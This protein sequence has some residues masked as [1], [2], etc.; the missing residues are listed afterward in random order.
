MNKK[1]NF[2]HQL[3]THKRV[4]FFYTP[5]LIALVIFNIG[6]AVALDEDNENPPVILY[7]LRDAIRIAFE[8]NLNIQIQEKEVTASRSDIITARS[9]FFPQV[10]ANASYTHNDK[11]LGENIFSGYKN[12]NQ[13]GLT[14]G[15]SIYSGGAN[16]AN[17]RQAQLKLRIQEETLNARKL[18][19]EFETKRLY[20]GLLLAYETV[21]IT[22]DLFDQAQAHYNDVQHKFDQGTSSRFDVL[23][24]KVQVSK[25]MPEL[26]KAKNAVDLI[27]AD[28][29]KLLV[30]K[31]R[32]ELGVEDRLAYNAIKINEPEF[33]K[34]AYLNQPQMNLKALGIDVNKWAI[35]LARSSYRPQINAELDYSYR[36]NNLNDMFN[37][38]QRN[39][40]AGLVVSVPIFDGFS[41]K[42]K[43]DA[44]KARYAEALL[45]KEDTAEQIAVDIKK[46]CL[47]LQQA[48]A[49]I[50]YTK[51][52]IGEAREA[53]K[54]SEV[55]YDNGEGTN[56][57]ILDA[58]VSLS[59]IE[60]DYSEGIYDY[61]MA[62]AFLNKTMG[63]IFLEETKNEKK[64]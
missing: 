16:M 38:S 37:R 17:F 12:D 64:D 28:L 49:I 2:W 27:K 15:Q 32:R 33:L 31:M 24:S 21:R 9:V 7:S 43:V 50:D 23:Q 53:L 3:S 29:K 30:I 63:R 26:V 55:S 20:Y 14:V 56:L 59:Q 35:Q 13:L 25:V 34:V 52:N 60:K 61:L 4:D 44:A 8:N 41:S 58:Q 18:D 10:N 48:Q 36:T 22:Q 6:Q 46:A 51:D 1:I 42:G 45:E 39:W 54:I 62:E 11:V 40:S 47:D 5:I 19:V 57:D